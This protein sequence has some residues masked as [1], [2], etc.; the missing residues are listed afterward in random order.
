MP[1]DIIHFSHANGFPA[2]CYAQ[3]LRDLREDYEVG[4]I[5][6]LGHD[7]RYPVTDGWAHLIAQVVDYVA[8]T[9]RRPVVAVGHSLGGFLSFLAA[10]TRPELFRAVVVMDAPV[11][12]YFKSK[13]L[14]VAKRIGMADRIMPGRGT[15]RRRAEWPSMDAAFHHLRGR[16]VFRHFTADCLHEYL[17]HGMR[18]TANGVG[19]RFDP[20]IEH[21]IYQTIPH[22]LYRHRNQLAVPAGFMVGRTSSMVSALDLAYMKW[23]YRMRFTR[24]DGG[25][26]F[27]FEHPV[28]TAAK[29]RVLLAKLLVSHPTT[30]DHRSRAR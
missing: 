22:D 27:P 25:H 20:K 11:L 16:G 17:Q 10:V 26:L 3:L 29:L 19:L 24:V 1:K 23:A 5:D 12:G 14:E 15:E 2:P 13:G 21:R 4:Y 7:A 18:H 8:A 9:Y 6:M 28:Q 30:T